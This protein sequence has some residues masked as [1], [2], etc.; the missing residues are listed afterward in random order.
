HTAERERADAWRKESELMAAHQ[1]IDNYQRLIERADRAE[2]NYARLAG[3]Y[4]E[5]A[6]YLRKRAEKAEAELAALQDKAIRFDL[7]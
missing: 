4:S 2:A 7:D 3:D 6:G 5:E 1:G